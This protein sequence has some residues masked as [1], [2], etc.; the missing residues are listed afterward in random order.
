MIGCNLTGFIL[1]LYFLPKLITTRY[2]KLNCKLL[3][4]EETIKLNWTGKDALSPHV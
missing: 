3:K 1:R 2:T 4:N